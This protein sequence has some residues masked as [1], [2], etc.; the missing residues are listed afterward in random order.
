MKIEQFEEEFKANK[1]D[2]SLI[3]SVIDCGDIKNPKETKVI[4]DGKEIQSR[5]SYIIRVE[6][7]R[8]KSQG[9]KNNG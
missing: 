2:E 8:E 9:G 5:V 4:V 7:K 6:S 3:I 1:A